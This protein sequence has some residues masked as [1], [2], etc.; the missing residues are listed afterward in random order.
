M[1]KC[2]K[3]PQCP[4]GLHNRML[5]EVEFC[6]THKYKWRQHIHERHCKFLK[7]PYVNHPLYGKWCGYFDTRDTKIFG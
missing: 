3:R 7:C 1:S 5:H 4:V 6:H 2:P